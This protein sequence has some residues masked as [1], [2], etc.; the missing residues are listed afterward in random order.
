[1]VQCDACNDEIPVNRHVYVGVSTLS[2]P[3]L[4]MHEACA[5]AFGL[6]VS[7]AAG[8]VYFDLKVAQRRA[9]G[10][11]SQPRRAKRGLTAG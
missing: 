6:G 7:A 5:V 2:G 9:R 4:A 3:P 8:H 1:L 10:G 11:G